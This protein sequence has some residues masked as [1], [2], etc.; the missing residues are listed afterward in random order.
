MKSHRI[1]LLLSL[2]FLAINMPAQDF[3]VIKETD[4]Y[5][6]KECDSVFFR[7]NGIF[8]YKEF[9]LDTTGK[10]KTDGSILRLPLYNN[11]YAEFKDTVIEFFN[12]GEGEFKFYG[13]N[14]SHEYYLVEGNYTNPGFYLIN[15]KN[16]DIDTL[17]DFPHFSPSGSC[18]CLCYDPMWE[19]GVNVIF[20]NL[21]TDK[22]V[23]ID[24]NNP[25]PCCVMWINDS[26]FMFAWFHRFGI[27]KIDNISKY[28]LVQIKK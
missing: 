26:S 17:P 11:K 1:P 12:H 18:Y 6:L 20:K 27:T 9:K 16:G 25:S 22:E 2:L 23:N 28:Y 13:E 15:K 3:K 10:F 19:G 8:I 7:N 5:I 21:K 14:N 4:D 24:F